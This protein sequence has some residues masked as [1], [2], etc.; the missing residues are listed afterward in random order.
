MRTRNEKLVENRKFQR[1][2][3]PL[4][5][6]IKILTDEEV[7]GGLNPLVAATQNI[8]LQGICLEVKQ[9]EINGIP[10][11]LGPPGNRAY[12]LDMEI[13]LVA[14]EPPLKAKG[15]VRWYDIARDSVEFMYLVGVLFVEIE[16]DG[17]EALK[18]FL[19][20]QGKGFLERLFGGLE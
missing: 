11:L 1:L 17:E 16:G 10:L 14:G 13:D 3:S 15:E 9:V 12:L 4:D 18:A 8:S 19:K 20:K 7:P 5:V 2:E 6:T